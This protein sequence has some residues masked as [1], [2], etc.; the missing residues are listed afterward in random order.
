MSELA[1]FGLEDGSW[2]IVELKDV[3]PGFRRAS[4]GR[5]DYLE[6]GSFER[7]LR[8]TVD[9]ANAALG[10]FRRLDGP[11][12]ELEIEFGIRLHAEAGAVVADNGEGHLH[13]RVL[14]HSSPTS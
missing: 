7:A 6:A 1:R 3:D 2:A 10:Q 11:P 5:G 8:G 12:D 13:V 14:W 4:V 9:V